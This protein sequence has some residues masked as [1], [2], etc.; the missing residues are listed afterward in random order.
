MQRKTALT[1]LKQRSEDD[2]L[3]GYSSQEF[4][5][6]AKQTLEA[7]RSR[8]QSETP[9]TILLAER[10]P[11]TFLAHFIAAC[12]T[13]CRIILGNPD[14]ADAEWQQVFELMTPDLIWSD[15]P[16]EQWRTTE[17]ERRSADGAAN[18]LFPLPITRYPLPLILIPTGGTSGNIRFVIHT[19]ETLM[20]SVDGFCQ[21]FEVEQV[22][23]FCVL[24]LY[25]VSGLMQFLRSFPTGGSLVVLPFKTVE[26]GDCHSIN[27]EDFFL[28]LVP[29]QLQRLLDGEGR[30]QR[31][32]VRGWK[33]GEAGGTE[34]AGGAHP[35][36][37][38][39]LAFILFF[40]VAHQ[41]GQIY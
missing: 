21:Y 22:N 13:N 39:Y 24:P 37:P 1:A 16:L 28:S 31:A 40:L 20:A 8:P 34:G 33:A 5:A 41:L 10:D 3:I 14:W 12:S 26:A 4:F 23:S 35:R 36:L 15:R 11:F 6:L 9:L 7:L 30:S 29:T 18:S 19:W 27:P 38:G 25:H 2:W 17:A 32:E